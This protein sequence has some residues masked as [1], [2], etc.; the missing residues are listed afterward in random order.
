VSK[1]KETGIIPIKVFWFI[2][3]AIMLSFL[4]LSLVERVRV[5]SIVFVFLILAMFVLYKMEKGGKWEKK[6]EILK[7]D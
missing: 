1:N 2:M 5:V 3:F 6:K 4:I 7:S